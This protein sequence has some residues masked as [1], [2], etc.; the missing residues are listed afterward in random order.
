ME[1]RCGAFASIKPIDASVDLI[2][3]APPL[4]FHSATNTYID[5]NGCSFRQLFQDWP[6][7]N[8]LYPFKFENEFNAWSS[9]FLAQ[10]Y[11][12]VGFLLCA[13]YL[14]FNIV[15]TKVM[16]N[17]TPFK[18]KRALQLW[19]LLLS[20]FSLIGFLRTAPHLLNTVIRDGFYESVRRSC[21]QQAYLPPSFHELCS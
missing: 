8:V 7:L 11:M 1:L 3:D 16:A 9:G 14:I 5:T 12:W 15:G 13:A 19:N 10:R 2:A 21:M 18:L 20:V 17:R 4:H 6:L